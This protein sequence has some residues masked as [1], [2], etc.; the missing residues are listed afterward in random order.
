MKLQKLE[1]AAARE[2][3]KRELLPHLYGFPYYKWTREFINSTNKLLFLTGANQISKALTHETLIPT[4]SGYKKMADLGVGDYVYTRLGN[5]TKILAVPFDGED[6]AFRIT[7]HDGSSI[8]ASGEHEWFCKGPEE[9]F[10]KTHSRYGEWVVRTTKEIIQHGGYSPSTTCARARYSIPVNEPLRFSGKILFDPYFLGLLLGDGCVTKHVSL[11]TADA[12]IAD[13]AVVNY[14]ARKSGKY[15]YR[16]PVDTGVRDILS[17]LGLLGTD[18][19]TKFIPESY[20]WGAV[21]Q[22]L[23]L[24]QGLMDTDGCVS[25]TGLCTFATASKQLAEDV[26]R[27]TQGL[28]G[29]GFIA[30]HPSHYIKDGA[31]H[32]ASDTYCVRVHL[33]ICPF[34]LPRKIARYRFPERCA[35]ERIIH[36]IEPIGK[37]RVKCITVCGEGS[38][39]AGKE[40]IVTHNSSTQIRKNITLAT[41][42][43][44][45]PELWRTRPITF[46][47]LYPSLKVA[48]HE[49][50]L[51]WIPEF[52]P[53][54][55]MKDDPQYGW[56]L[57]KSPN[58][59]IA[60]FK[61]NSGI[62][63]LFKSYDQQVENLQTGTV[64]MLSIDEELPIELWP[65][66]QLRVGATDGYIAGVFT[67]TLS[68]QYWFDVME[69]TD[70]LKLKLP[71][72]H[73]MRV[74]L[75]DC[76]TYENGIPSDW[77]IE[78]IKKIEQTLPTP[79][80]VL[81][82]VYGRFI[83]DKSVLKF[84]S[85][86]AEVNM[87]PEHQIPESW[88]YFVG[89]DSGSGVQGTKTTFSHPAAIVFVAVDPSFQKA[90]VT[91]VWIG[92]P[93]NI[94]GDDKNTTASDILRQYVYMRVG[95]Q[96]VASYYDYAD[97][98]LGIV[99]E[100]ESIP[101]QKAEKRH[102]IGEGLINTLF[103][104]MMLSIFKNKGGLEL[105]DE[106][107]NLRNDTQKQKAKDHAS[108]A[109]RYALSS[110]T[111]DFMNVT[112]GQEKPEAPK[113]ITTE[114]MIA[115]RRLAYQKRTEII[116]LEQEIE[117][118]NED[119]G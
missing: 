16:I 7:F 63:L 23:A 14:G 46:W 83:I 78:R 6:E 79:E 111:F 56:E 105:A 55:E 110:V 4:P 100:R 113:I 118:L 54:G 109:L 57:I 61:F 94:T 32:I 39:V 51:K 31:K 71:S 81:R 17:E 75:Y 70:P 44:R 69:E 59:L 45:W 102:E 19:F 76:L 117:E 62:N 26:V 60:G 35:H 72:A 12:E 73:K 93:D 119:Y 77:T 101:I 66:L 10:R 47:Y 24:L 99:A 3:R 38:F 40:S 8:E 116:D 52:M 86:N 88:V 114:M 106:L 29:L 107:L 112:G 90:I 104:N 98:D 65:E 64:W 84:P 87:I 97:R 25:R 115:D 2:A 67:P 48:D 13:Y 89:I 34:R 91:D 11:T 33:P 37:K 80:E 58:G 21:E 15:G 53:R 18:C 41:E 1:E 28:G 20:F 82:R 85:F 49:A 50:R 5:P 43:D 108:D 27:L 74:S 36:K 103:K 42:P 9:R 92:T 96:V 30:K 22:R 68:Q 95:K